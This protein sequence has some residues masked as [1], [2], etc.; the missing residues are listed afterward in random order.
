RAITQL[1]E[2]RQELRHAGLI[3][4][5]PDHPDWRMMLGLPQEMLAGAEADL[6]PDI[7][8]RH[9]EGLARRVEA[10]KIERQPRQ[11]QAAQAGLVRRELRPLAT[12]VELLAVTFRMTQNARLIASARSVFSHEKPPSASGSRPK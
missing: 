8:D 6:E 5:G 3:G 1:V 11:Q 10:C 12:A 9:G 2:A 4:F 7:V